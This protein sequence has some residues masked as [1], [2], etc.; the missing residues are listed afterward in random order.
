MSVSIDL[1]EFLRNPIH[2]G[3]QRVTAQI[4]R[5]WPDGDLRPVHL[6]PQGHLAALPDELLPAIAHS[7]ECPG[8]SWVERIQEIRDTPGWPGAEFSARDTLLVPE[9]F[10]D[11][12]RVAFFRRMDRT[13]LERCR[14]VVYDLLPLVYPQYFASWVPMDIVCAYFQMIRGVP[15][16]AFISRSTQ[17]DYCRR[18]RR[19]RETKGVVFRLGSDGLGPKPAPVASARPLKFTVVGRLEPW[20][21]PSLILDAFEPLLRDVAGLQLHFLGPL[22]DHIEPS[23][24]A[25]LEVMAAHHPGLSHCPHPDDGTMRRHIDESRATIFVSVAEGFGLPPV[26]SLWRGTPVIVSRGLPSLE[27]Y[28]PAGLH[29]V[30]PL[31]AANLRSA[32]TAFFDDAYWRQ[33]SQEAGGLDLP[34]WRSFTQ[35]LAQWCQ[36]R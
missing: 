1:T 8:G 20:K 22:G 3:I 12:R 11:P 36:P 17:E 14:F 6:A 26:E 27:G 29:V 7:F 35:E 24:A 30:E 18:L 28:G 21:N 9:L 31:D 13:G 16:C 19:S 10:Y 32:V 4:C 15:H 33:K 34:T 5:N 2:S 23:L 25:R